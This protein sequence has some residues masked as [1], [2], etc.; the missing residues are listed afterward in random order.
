MIV[1][2]EEMAKRA[3]V[4]PRFLKAE[5]EAGRV[6]ALKAGAKFLFNP[7]A[8]LKVLSER[9]ANSQGRSQDNG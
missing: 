1:E 8:V 9:A 4:P 6:P 7:Q 3:K 2:L 5:A